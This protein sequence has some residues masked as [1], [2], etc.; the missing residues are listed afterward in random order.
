MAGRCFDCEGTEP[1]TPLDRRSQ[2]NFPFYAS[3]SSG[4]VRI[5]FESSDFFVE[6]AGQPTKILL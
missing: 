1:A 4:L 3:Q 6:G 2:H 5:P